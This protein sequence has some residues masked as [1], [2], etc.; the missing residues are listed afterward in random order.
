MVTRTATNLL[1][2]DAVTYPATTGTSEWL[3]ASG[4]PI[5][6]ETVAVGPGTGQA[7]SPTGLVDAPAYPIMGSVSVAR[8]V[9]TDWLLPLAQSNLTIPLS[10]ELLKYQTLDTCWR[11]EAWVGVPWSVPDSSAWGALFPFWFGD[12]F[13][14][15][16]PLPDEGSYYGYDSDTW[17]AGTP[18]TDGC[19]IQTYGGAQL[20]NWNPTLYDR[21][22]ELGI[23]KNWRH[24]L[25]SFDP[26]V[27][28]D[29]SDLHGSF[30]VFLNGKLVGS[31]LHTKLASDMQWADKFRL[32]RTLMYD[33]LRF[34]VGGSPV[35]AEFE[36]EFVPYNLVPANRWTNLRLATES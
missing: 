13:G 7:M 10:P 5:F 26:W 29:S 35:T 17:P 27:N 28:P 18:V 16:N 11:I 6:D 21:H 25:V 14:L 32:Y 1:S 15:V 20:L 2:A 4:E 12:S 8:P 23:P 22:T 9:G 33:R 30:R 36:P 24:Y 3:Y 31:I 19:M 34:V